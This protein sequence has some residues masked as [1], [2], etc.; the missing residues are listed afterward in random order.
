MVGYHSSRRRGALSR[1]T[2]LECHVSKTE[3]VWVTIA[4]P[5][6]SMRTA[7]TPDTWNVSHRPV[8]HGLL[9]NGLGVHR[10]T[11]NEHAY[12]LYS[13]QTHG[14][15]LI[16]PVVYGHLSPVAFSSSVLSR[17]VITLGRRNLSRLSYSV[18]VSQRPVVTV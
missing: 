13:R 16:V 8:V 15:S 11:C 1:R 14:M 7:S 2:T 5:A 12:C 4:S 18:H 3:K 6:K 17:T 9:S 10:G